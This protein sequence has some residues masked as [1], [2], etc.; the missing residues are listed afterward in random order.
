[1]NFLPCKN[2][3]KTTTTTSL[4]RKIVTQNKN[5]RKF[6]NFQIILRS[7]PKLSKK[8][9]PGKK[10]SRPTFLAVGGT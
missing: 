7:D 4:K 2:F 5:Y 6:I 8:W 10:S 1:M 9:Q 3:Q